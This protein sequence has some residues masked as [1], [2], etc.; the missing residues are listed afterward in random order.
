MV[1]GGSTCKRA[2]SHS[3]LARW[4][5]CR[6]AGRA[7]GVLC[8]YVV[9]SGL[10]VESSLVQAPVVQTASSH[11]GHSVQQADIVERP[12]C[13]LLYT[14]DAADERSSVDLGGRRI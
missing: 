5:H 6:G 11:L 10:V 7:A 8:R 4:P 13:C 3:A 2:A 1:A 9:G 12:H 14:S